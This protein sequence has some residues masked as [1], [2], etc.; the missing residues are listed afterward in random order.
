MASAERV[1]RVGPGEVGGPRFTSPAVWNMTGANKPGT[2]YL[3]KKAAGSDRFVRVRPVAATGTSVPLSP[4]RQGDRSPRSRRTTT[5]SRSR[6]PGRSTSADGDDPDP[7]RAELVAALAGLNC[8]CAEALDRD[9]MQSAIDAACAGW[10][11]GFVFAWGRIDFER[12]HIC[13]RCYGELTFS[14]KALQWSCFF[15]FRRIT[16][17]LLRGAA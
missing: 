8:L 2:G 6:S 10:A 12:D 16:T 1:N 5:R 14:R 11:E 3:Q 17:E 15:C 13:P 4:T 7:E 9:D